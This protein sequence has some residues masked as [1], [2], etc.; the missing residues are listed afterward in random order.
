[1][2]F[3]E[4]HFYQYLN[5]INNFNLHKQ[6]DKLYH[7]YHK[8]P[9][10]M[11][12]YGP[13]GIGKYS[14]ALKFVSF[15]SQSNLKYEKKISI[16]HDKTEYFFRLSDIHIDIDLNTLGCN[17]KLV[18]NEFFS[19]LLNIISVNKKHFFI[20][21]KNFHNIH[22]ELHEVF[23]TFMQTIPNIKYK[24]YFILLTN[25]I[26]FLNSNILLSTY[27]LNLQRPNKTAYLQICNSKNIDIYNITSIKALKS[28]ITINTDSFLLSLFNQ[29]I[30]N[31]N[32]FFDIRN[33]LYDILIFNINIDTC[34]WYV[35]KQFSILHKDI[36]LSF[37][38]TFLIYNFY[39]QFN[40]NYRP[41]YHLE[42]LFINLINEHQRIMQNT[43][44]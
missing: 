20:V 6:I 19:N 7:L 39:F 10:N 11:I 44:N 24:L 9:Q 42:R 15:F 8:Y 40:N 31:N 1:M 43:E 25:N 22:N 4:F 14:Q 18:W 17:S 28:N 34:I 35:F 33:I 41:I 29:I 12:L 2:N 21:C 26:S 30:K 5:S 13:P 23:Y 38:I 3:H 37:D 27:I 36:T 16:V 32:N